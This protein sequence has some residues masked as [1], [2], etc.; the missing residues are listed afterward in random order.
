MERR[1]AGLKFWIIRGARQ[2]YADASHLLALLRACGERPR[3]R[4]TAE[5]RDELAPPH[6]SP[7]RL[8]TG[9]S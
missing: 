4:P 6:S 5:Q 3:Y 9:A 2:Q 8:R 1:E 7:P